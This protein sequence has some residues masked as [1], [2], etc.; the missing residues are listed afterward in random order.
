MQDPA[1]W[2][3]GA[4]AAIVVAGGIAIAIKSSG[5]SRRRDADLRLWAEQRGYQF[6]DRSVTLLATADRAHLADRIASALPEILMQRKTLEHDYYFGL[7]FIIS[8]VSTGGDTIPLIDG[9]AFDWLAKLGANRKL[10]FI[11]S[12]IGSQVAAFAFR[13]RPA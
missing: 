10:A 7:R 1:L 4:F 11:A 8:A 2:F 3:G 12:A 5:K 13:A 9:G 6:A